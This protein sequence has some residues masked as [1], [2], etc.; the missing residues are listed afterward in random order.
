[1]EMSGKLPLYQRVIDNGADITELSPSALLETLLSF[2][3]PQKDVSVGAERLLERFGSASAAMEADIADILDSLGGDVKASALVKLSADFG[4]YYWMDRLKGGKQFKGVDD[5]AEYCIFKYF[6]DKRESLSVLMLDK[7]LR[8]LGIERLAEGAAC[9]VGADFEAIG[10]ALFRY[11]AQNYLLVHNHPG[12]E[13]YPSDDD[14]SLT[15]RLYAV[16]AP[17][18]KHMMEHIIISSNKYL[19]IMQLMRKRGYD[20]YS[21]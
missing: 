2:V 14:L 17:F 5:I 11:G 16:T 10:S 12:V 9:E 6:K 13:P 20:F 7:N 15:E 3:L 21:H 4:R 19:P 8:M 18:G 1:M